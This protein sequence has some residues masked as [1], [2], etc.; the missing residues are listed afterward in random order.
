ML[1][2]LN[3]S[4]EVNKTQLKMYFFIFYVEKQIRAIKQTVEMKV[5]CAKNAWFFWMLQS[6]QLYWCNE[7]DVAQAYND[8]TVTLKR[9]ES[10]KGLIIRQFIVCKANKVFYLLLKGANSPTSP[11]AAQ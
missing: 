10:M 7:F 4:S 2:Q 3:N 1:N 6:I 9:K 8:I 11:V 5:M